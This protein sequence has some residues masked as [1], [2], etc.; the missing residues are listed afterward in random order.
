M[1]GE[2]SIISHEIL[3]NKLAMNSSVVPSD[4]HDLYSIL[5]S[6]C[7]GS[8]SNHHISGVLGS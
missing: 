4:G 8:V 3:Q 6:P 7:E 5:R 1:W 2:V